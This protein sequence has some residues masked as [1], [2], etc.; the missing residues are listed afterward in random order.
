MVHL[1]NGMVMA[2]TPCLASLAMPING[3]KPAVAPAPE[4]RQAG[5][6]GPKRP[7]AVTTTISSVAAQGGGPRRPGLPTT[8]PKTELAENK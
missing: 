1:V 8:A 6:G 3:L 5:E 2:L 4:A 7:G